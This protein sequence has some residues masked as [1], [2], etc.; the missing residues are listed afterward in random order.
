MNSGGSGAPLRILH[1]V[2]G[3]ESRLAG[4]SSAFAAAFRAQLATGLRV[5]VLTPPT[6]GPLNA[7]LDDVLRAVQAAGC[8]VLSCDRIEADLEEAFARILAAEQAEGRAV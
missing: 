3:L 6:H 8:R 2:P 5:G 7:D 4:L 1:V